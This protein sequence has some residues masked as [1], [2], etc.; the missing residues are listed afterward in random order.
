FFNMRAG[1]LP[2]TGFLRRN[3]GVVHAGRRHQNHGCGIGP[4]RAAETAFHW[5]PRIVSFLHHPGPASAGGNATSLASDHDRSKAALMSTHAR[6]SAT[7]C[8]PST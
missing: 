2:V 3:A 5:P 8:A 6:R 7:K 1:L 4:D